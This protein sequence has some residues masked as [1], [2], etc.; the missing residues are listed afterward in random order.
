M[1]IH[2]WVEAVAKRGRE[3]EGEKRSGGMGRNPELL[4]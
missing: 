1:E 4:D 3:G 2:D